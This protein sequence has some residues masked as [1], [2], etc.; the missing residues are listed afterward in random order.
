MLNKILGSLNCANMLT[1]TVSVEKLNLY[2]T[3]VGLFVKA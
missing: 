1:K 2:A 3:S